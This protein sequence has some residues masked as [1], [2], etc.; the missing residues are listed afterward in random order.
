MEAARGT[1]ATISKTFH[2][3]ERRVPKDL[4]E[5]EESGLVEPD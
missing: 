1:K 5:E 2:W 4:A 3:P